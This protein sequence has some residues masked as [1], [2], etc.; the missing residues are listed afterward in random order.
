MAQ[1]TGSAPKYVEVE[2][3]AVSVAVSGDT[4]LLEIPVEGINEVGI[5]VAVSTNNLDAFKVL[6]KMHKNAAYQT[7]YSA[8]GDYTSPVGLV[9][10]AS[11]NLTA[12]AASTTGWL[13]LDVSPLCAV[14][15]TA[16]A[17]TGAAAVDARAIG[18][19]Y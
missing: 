13:M 16:S 3:L 7:L 5:E 15:I 8:S 9:I 17:V 18:K 10:G 14:K 4:T 19:G 6:G 2:N 12:Q 1:T 11:G